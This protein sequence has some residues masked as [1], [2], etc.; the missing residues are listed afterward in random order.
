MISAARTF[1]ALGTVIQFKAYGQNA[2]NACDKATDKI[3]EIDNNMSVFIPDSEIS[4]INQNA[5]IAET[6]VSADTYYV[7]S[8]AI[9][10]SSI[11]KGAFDPTIRPMT[12]LWGILTENASIPDKDE[13]DRDISLVNYRDIILNDKALSV[14]LKSRNQALDLG[15]IAKGFAADQVKRIF[16]E[17]GIESAIIDLGGNISAMGCKSDTTAWRIGIQDPLKRRGQ[18]AG[19]INVSDKSV[20]T[21]GNYERYFINDGRRYHHLIDPVT[22]S[23]CDNGIISATIISDKSIDGDALSTCAFVMGLDKGLKL[24]ESIEGI[25][26]IFITEGKKIHITSGIVE[27]F[28]VSENAGYILYSNNDTALGC[29]SPTVK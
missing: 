27:S 3:Y 16:S 4:K 24:V 26:A 25:D 14:R 17:Y 22:G 19:I 7:I 20:V 1:Y 21:S 2:E 11:S 18:F 28:K 13:I 8:Q 6:T 23:P 10:Y 9:K 5:G 12:S 15:A 29:K